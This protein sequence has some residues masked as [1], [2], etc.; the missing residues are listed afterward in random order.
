MA[1]RTS[2]FATRKEATIVIWSFFLLKSG[3]TPTYFY[4][5]ILDLFNLLPREVEPR[6]TG[7]Y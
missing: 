6:L 1:L 3:E 7:C 5:F 4:F 2:D